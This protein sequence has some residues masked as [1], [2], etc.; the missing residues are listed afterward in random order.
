MVLGAAG[1]RYPHFYPAAKG[2]WLPPLF[3]PHPL[4]H[5]RLSAGQT[6][7]NLRP[8]GHRTE[9]HRALLLGPTIFWAVRLTG[10]L[11][12]ALLLAVA[13]HKGTWSPRPL[14]RAHAGRL[15]QPGRSTRYLKVSESCPRLLGVPPV[16]QQR[17]YTQGAANPARLRDRALPVSKGTESAAQPRQGQEG[18]TGARSGIK[19]SRC[20]AR[21]KEATEIIHSLKHTIKLQTCS[22]CRKSP[23]GTRVN[24][25]RVQ[26]CLPLPGSLAQHTAG[27]LHRVPYPGSALPRH[28]RGPSVPFAVCHTDGLAQGNRSCRC[29]PNRDLPA[30]TFRQRMKKSPARPLSWQ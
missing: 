11:L 28:V 17:P 14:C 7:A 21:A 5:T 12:A 2:S 10:S 8:R 27:P 19:G 24:P 22:W 30:L 20:P 26:G 15:T 23:G 6:L 3:Q 18:T 1:P 13:A 25:F 9:H 4:P 16:S 29:A